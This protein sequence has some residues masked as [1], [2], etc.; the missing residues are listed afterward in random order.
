MTVTKKP[1]LSFATQATIHNKQTKQ[2]KYRD[3]LLR[4]E[5]NALASEAQA[6]SPQFVQIHIIDWNFYCS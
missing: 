5:D 4:G 2:Q 3:I 1:Q 6:H